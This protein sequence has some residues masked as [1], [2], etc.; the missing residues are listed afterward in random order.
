MPWWTGSSGGYTLLMLGKQRYHH[1]IFIDLLQVG[2]MH[3]AGVKTN[4]DSQQAL[5]F[6]ILPNL[7]KQAQ[8][9]TCKWLHTIAQPINDEIH[10]PKDL[11]QT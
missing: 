8:K 2:D 4:L 1:C 10:Q 7:G 11:R 6:C 9:P 3:T 5:L